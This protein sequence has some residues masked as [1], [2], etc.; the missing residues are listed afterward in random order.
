MFLLPLILS[1]CFLFM[2]FSRWKISY[3]CERRLRGRSQ[4]VTIVFLIVN[5]LT[6]QTL[7]MTNTNNIHLIIVF[8]NFFFFVMLSLSELCLLIE[9]FQHNMW[10]AFFRC[11]IR[12]YSFLFIPTSSHLGLCPLFFPFYSYVRMTS[13]AVVLDTANVKPVALSK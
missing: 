13:L 1:N 7:T 5:K 9:S 3:Q 4:F 8:I 12:Q 6:N 10:I 2:K 11:L